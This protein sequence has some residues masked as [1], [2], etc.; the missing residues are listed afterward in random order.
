MSVGELPEGWPAEVEIIDGD[1][2]FGVGGASDGENEEGWA[3]TT[4]SDG[5][6]PIAEAQAVLESAA[7]VVD[8]SRSGTDSAGVVA[9]S[10]ADYSV[11]VA[12]DDNGLLYTVT[13]AR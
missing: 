5:A 13:P 3:V 6:D 9:L 10:N 1:I 12:G 4:A 7:F 2:R 8:A 11:V